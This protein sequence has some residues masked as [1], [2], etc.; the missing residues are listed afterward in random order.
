MTSEDIGS[1]PWS[2]AQHDTIPQVDLWLNPLETHV[3]LSAFLSVEG[4]S[5]SPPYTPLRKSIGE[6]L[7]EVEERQRRGQQ[8]NSDV[9]D[10][11]LR[12]W[13][14]TFEN[15]GFLYLDD[16]SGVIRLSRLGIVVRDLYTQ[17]NRRIE[18]AN[19]HLAQ[20]AIQVLNRYTL[21]NPIHP[22]NYP[23]DADLRPLNLIWKAMR[24]LDDRLHWE[25]LN[26]VLMHVNYRRDEDAA[27]QHIHAVR[28]QAKGHYDPDSLEELGTPAVLQG[29]ETKR[30]ITPWFT[31]AGFGGLLITSFDD[32]DGFR[33]LNPKYDPLIDEALKQDVVPSVQCLNSRSKYLAWL[34]D[35]PGISETPTNADDE[36]NIKTVLDAIKHYAKNKII[37]LSGLPGTGKSRLAKLV[38]ERVIQGDS[39]RY[40]E[41]QFNENTSYSDFMEGFVPKPDG[42]GFELVPK[43]LFTINRRAS[44]DPA[45]NTYVLLIE[46]FTRANVHGVLGE[47]ITYIEHRDRPFKLT[48]SQ[49]EMSVSP[50]LV[51]MAT[52]NPRDKSALVL[53]HAILR[54]LHIV[55]CLPS[56]ESLEA[57]LNQ[58][59]PTEIMAKLGSW[60][61]KYKAVLPFGH[62]IFQGVNSE[63][64]LKT[65]WTGTVKYFLTDTSG[66]I[67]PQYEEPAMEYPWK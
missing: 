9:S 42:S 16:N 1:V 60:F 28:T 11:R 36:H 53:D 49:S 29:T 18:G 62:G 22:A 44:L 67:K 47:L 24:H 66:N 58:S 20:V 41:I 13:K 3:Y 21:R 39:Y 48:F 37:C 65:V 30:R 55:E 52:M 14:S 46:E 43:V 45:G 2:V 8:P 23:E 59:L 63:E 38:A 51:V 25:E 32:Q 50:N 7:Q 56:V 33:Q 10:Q 34:T 35:V 64:D 26:R 31:R 19:D 57:M 61:Q 5:F 6:I 27:I 15:L 40:S 12:T 54:R 17:L 4:E